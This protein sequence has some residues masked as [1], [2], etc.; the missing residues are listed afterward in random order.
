MIYHNRSSKTSIVKFP[1][2]KLVKILL[3]ANKIYVF[4]KNLFSS[5]FCIL[6]EKCQSKL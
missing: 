1:D 3:F 4:L 6:A 5:F 2:T